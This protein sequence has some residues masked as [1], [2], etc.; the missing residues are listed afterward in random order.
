MS[1]ETSAKYKTVINHHDANLMVVFSKISTSGGY[2]PLTFSLDDANE[3]AQRGTLW[4][5][6]EFDWN[7]NYENDK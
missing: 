2:K 7:L 5:A 1:G 3:T 4:S 6:P